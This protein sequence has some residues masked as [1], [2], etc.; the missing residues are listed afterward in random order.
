MFGFLNN[1]HSPIGLDIGHDSIKLIQLSLDNK[2][3]VRLLAGT[4]IARPSE[5]EPATAAWQRW[6]IDAVKKNIAEGRFKGNKVAAAIPATEVFVDHLKTPKVEQDRVE[7][8][9]LAKIQQKLPFDPSNALIKCMPTEQNNVL[10]MVTDRSIIE[11]HLAIYEKANLALKS[12][13]VWPLALANTYGSFFG[14]RKSDLNAVVMLLDI[15]PHC[16]NLV[17]SRHTDVMFARSIPIGSAQ[18]QV[19]ANVNRLVMELITCRKQ[20]LSAYRGVGIERLIFL[21]GRAVEGG[22]CANI[23]KQLEMKAQ[24]GDCIAAIG[25]ADPY[26]CG[27]DRRNTQVTWATAFGLS[28]AT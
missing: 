11:R 25:V 13:G 22:V 2:K 17:I 26:K 18:L 24:I 4:S 23:A 15:E 6:A 5:V 8:A 28:L 14:R 9:V 10:A 16:S 1:R 12:I 7:D 19:E 27:I 21:S 20:F 3:G